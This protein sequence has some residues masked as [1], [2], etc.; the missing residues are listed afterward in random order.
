MPSSK[1]KQVS[2]EESTDYLEPLQYDD[3]PSSSSAPHVVPSKK[4]STEKKS[5]SPISYY[6]SIYFLIS[7]LLYASVPITQFIMGI[8]YIGQCPIR[9]FLP[10]YMILS[11]IFGIA[12]VL[13]GIL[14]YFLWRRYTYSYERPSLLVRTLKPILIFLFLFVLGWWIA[15][16]VLVFEIKTRVDVVFPVLPEYCQVHLYKAAYVLIFVDYIVITLVIILAIVNRILGSDK[17]N[18]SKKKKTK[19]PKSNA[20]RPQR[21]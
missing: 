6:A 1:S 10:I 9:Q 17:P 19:R 16:Q 7:I 14:V 21:N 8:I 11:G 13:V 15:G 18:D 12:F 2:Y 4:V 5:S 3:H 20:K